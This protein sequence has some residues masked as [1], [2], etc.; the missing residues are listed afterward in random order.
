MYKTTLKAGPVIDIYYRNFTFEYSTNGDQPNPLEAM[1]AAITGCAGVYAK[2]SCKSLGISD[3][4]ISISVKPIASPNNPLLPVRIVTALGFP[5]EFTPEQR[6]EVQ[7]S[8]SQC[9]VKEL[10]AEGASIEFVQEEVR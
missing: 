10:I 3:E 1:Y 8:V 4:G 2:K 7:A 9:A 6:A 5:S